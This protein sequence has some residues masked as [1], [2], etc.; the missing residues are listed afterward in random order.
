[1][2]VGSPVPG[3]IGLCDSPDATLRE[4]VRQTEVQ[5]N[6]CDRVGDPAE[7][8]GRVHDLVAGVCPVAAFRNVARVRNTRYS[9]IS[10]SMAVW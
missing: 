5:V 10:V 6:V 9:R 8:K 3:G 7:S 1:M 4:G 2:Q